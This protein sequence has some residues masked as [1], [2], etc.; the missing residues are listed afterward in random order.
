ML[1]LGST[2][3]NYNKSADDLLNKIGALIAQND[4]RIFT[5]KVEKCRKAKKRHG[6]SELYS[7][8][9]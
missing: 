1:E 3:I 6:C 5:K 9:K 2:S 8:T 4:L 7:I